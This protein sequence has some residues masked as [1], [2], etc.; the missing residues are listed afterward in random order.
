MATAFVT[1]AN[2]GLGLEFARQLAGRGDRVYAACRDP[3]SADE[4]KQIGGDVRVVRLDV[5]DAA[6]CKSAA[7]EVEGEV[8]LLVNNAGVFG[9]KAGEQTPETY[10]A[11]AALD[12]YRTNVAGVVMLTAA[13]ADKLA[14]P[15]KA[16][17]ISSGYGSIQH[18]NGD[19][20]LYYCCSKAAVNMAG[21][22][23]AERMRQRGVIVASLSPGWVQ[24][25][26]GGENANLT[27]AESISSMLKVIDGLGPAD[28]GK[29]FG[30]TGEPVPF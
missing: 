27:P 12:V 21:K 18:A 25:D 24:T 20:P 19:W 22:I 5:A 29:F 10:E 23:L 7:G 28:A 26:M 9:P 17:T 15:S 2:R 11:E 16:V 14:E 4:L 8:D 13:L 30:H 6:S 1:G 3:D